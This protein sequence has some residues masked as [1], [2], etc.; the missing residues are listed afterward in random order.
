MLMNNNLSIS[1]FLSQCPIGLLYINPSSLE[2]H[3]SRHSKVFKWDL[4]SVITS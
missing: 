2:H 1:Y 3:Q 4:E